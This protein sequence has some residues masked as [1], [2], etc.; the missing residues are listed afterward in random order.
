MVS[1]L[2]PSHSI[3]SSKVSATVQGVVL[4]IIPGLSLIFHLPSSRDFALGCMKKKFEISKRNLFKITKEREMYIYKTSTHKK[5][6]DELGIRWGETA[7]LQQSLPTLVS[8]A[9][10]DQMVKTARSTER[11]QAQLQAPAICHTGS[12]PTLEFLPEGKKKICA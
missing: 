3:L 4:K 5:G 11:S 7:A 6:Q 10:P 1:S 12:S 2:K 9:E 8:G